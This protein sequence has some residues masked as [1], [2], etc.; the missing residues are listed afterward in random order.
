MKGK[1]H[2]GQMVFAFLNTRGW[3]EGKWRMMIKKKSMMSQGQERQNG[4]T[5]QNGMKDIRWLGI[6]AGRQIGQKKGE[7]EGIIMKERDE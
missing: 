7:G 3:N 2:K 4:M 6:G 5:V 1:A